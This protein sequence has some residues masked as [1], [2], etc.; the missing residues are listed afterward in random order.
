MVC[1]T[2]PCKTYPTGVSASLQ[3]RQATFPLASLPTDLLGQVIKSLPEVS[4]QPRLE[5]E[6]GEPGAWKPCSIRAVC[7][8]LR[9]PFDNS[10][11]RLA[12][13]PWRRPTSSSERRVYQSLIPRLMA[14]TPGLDN[15]CFH[16]LDGEGGRKLEKLPVPWGQ[17]RQLQLPGLVRG[18]GPRNRGVG[19]GRGSKTW[20]SPRSPSAR[21]SGSWRS[22]PDDGRCSRLRTPSMAPHASSLRSHCSRP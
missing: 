12:L 4:A 19:G 6:S 2:P 10:N 9:D 20:S 13:A 8:S 3:Q 11:E 5:L 16:V 7:R 1:V 18:P 21:R 22:T 14:R 17:L 15:L